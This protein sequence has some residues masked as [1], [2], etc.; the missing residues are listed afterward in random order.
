MPDADIAWA[1]ATVVHALGAS[2]FEVTVDRPRPGE[3]SPRITGP[4]LIDATETGLAGMGSL[5]LQVRFAAYGASRLPFG[6]FF[7]LWVV[8]VSRL[9]WK[10]Q[11][12]SVNKKQLP[13][14]AKQAYPVWKKFW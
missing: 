12:L 10:A 7:F 2:K 5:P 14:E 9:S 6:D 1:P 3:P 13:F 11:M 8:T 4:V